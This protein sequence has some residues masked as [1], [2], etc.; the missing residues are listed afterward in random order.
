M[1]NRYEVNIY[2]RLE[3]QELIPCLVN[4]LKKEWFILTLNLGPT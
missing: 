4:H 1:K 2:I 3:R